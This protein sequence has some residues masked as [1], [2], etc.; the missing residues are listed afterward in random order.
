[1]ERLTVREALSLLKNSPVDM[2]DSNPLSGIICLKCRRQAET[3]EVRHELL[4]EYDPAGRQV[5]SRYTGRNTVTIG[6]R[7]G[8]KHSFDI[9]RK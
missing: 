7:C 4:P 9:R 1:M 5:G 8:Y 2:S 3:F 6:C